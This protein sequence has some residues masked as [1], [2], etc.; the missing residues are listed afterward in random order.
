MEEEE[1]WYDVCI[2]Y[3]KRATHA[4]RALL[5]PP[6]SPPFIQSAVS[7][8]FPAHNIRFLII[9]KVFLSTCNALSSEGGFP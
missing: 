6:P 8:R 4:R 7:L 2:V 5:P 3:I 9:N 1:E